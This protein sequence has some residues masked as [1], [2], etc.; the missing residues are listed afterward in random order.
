MTIK[1]ARKAAHERLAALHLPV[2]VSRSE[3]EI[4]LAHTL[5]RDRTWLIAHPEEPL[6]PSKEKV[7]LT[8]VHRRRK[9]EPIAYLTGTKE[10]YGLT[11]HVNKHALIPR[12][13]TEEMIDLVQRLTTNDLRSTLIWDVGTGSGAIAISIKHLFPNTTVIA[14]DISKRA[15]S[16]AQKNAENLLSTEHGIQFVQGSLL[17]KQIKKIIH[18]QPPTQLIILANLPYLPFSDRSILQKDVVN[19]EPH[20]A[21]FTEKDGNAL[22]I[23][24][25][26][27]LRTFAKKHSIPVHAFFEFDPPQAATLKQEAALLFSGADIQIHEDTCGRKRFLEIGAV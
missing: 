13:E 10:F 1:E 19:F 8:L 24:L 23:K 2:D 14:S 9:H 6:S 20:T 26:N 21:L 18:Q 3:A 16:L 22:I 11:F 7:F 25:L 27:Q 17:T 5:K 4:L 12:P 15:L